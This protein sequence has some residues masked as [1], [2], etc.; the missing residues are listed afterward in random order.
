MKLVTRSQLGWPASAAPSQSSTKGVKVHYEGTAVSTKL[1]TDHDACLDEWKNIRRSHL[2]NTAE[3]YSDVAYNFAACPHGYLLEGR[4]LRRRTGANGNQALNR[5]HFAILGLVGSSGL[6]EPT[7][8]M[9]SAIRDGIDL[10]RKNGAGAE[11]KGHRDGYATSC[12][13]GPLYAWVKKGAPR[14]DTAPTNPPKENPV[15]PLSKD[16]VSAIWKTDGILAA[17]S[18]AAKGNTH[19]TADSYLRDIHA[20]VRASQTEL[21]AVNVTVRTLV[22][23]LASRDDAVDVEALI[24]RIRAAIEGVTVRL[25]T[26]S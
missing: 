24:A 23:A 26:E 4:G 10:L 22:E 20:R 5:A 12:P 9:L 1:L 15:M 25:E 18:T 13:G 21:A 11:I 16:D 8:A 7:D 2:A 6:T 3:N 17:P 14:P 19:W